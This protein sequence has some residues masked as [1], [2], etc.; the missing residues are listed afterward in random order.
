MTPLVRWLKKK[1]EAWLGTY[2]EGPKAPERLREQVVA[3]ANMYPTA[4]RSQWVEFAGTFAAQSYEAGYLRGIEWVE[5]DPDAFDPNLPPEVIADQIDPDWRWRPM[6]EL[7]RPPNEVVTDEKPE[8]E[9]IRDQVD[10]FARRL[11]RGARVRRF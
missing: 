1:A 9:D 8:R 10:A 3:F 7:E 11:A 5:R 4:T 2:Y 6:I